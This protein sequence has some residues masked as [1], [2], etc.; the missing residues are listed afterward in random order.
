MNYEK[1][2]LECKNKYLKPKKELTG[3]INGQNQKGGNKKFVMFTKKEK[4]DIIKSYN[5]I[6][7]SD[8]KCV[9]HSRKDIINASKGMFTYPKYVMKK[10]NSGEI[11]YTINKVSNEK[12]N[13]VPIV[14]DDS[15]TVWCNNAAENYGL[16]IRDILKMKPGDR[17]EVI[18][19]DRN[20]GDYI[21]GYKKGKKYDPRKMG[22]TYGTYIHGSN[23]NGILIF[24]GDLKG[25]VYSPFTWEINLKAHNDKSYFWGPLPNNVDKCSMNKNNKR[26]NKRKK[27]KSL[28]EKIKVGWRGPSINLKDA[29]K[30]PNKVTHYSNWWNDYAPLRHHNYLKVNRKK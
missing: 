13:D 25:E 1:E 3:Q 16:E 18:F 5:K 29:N 27:E 17:M 10:K 23:L 21:H 12:G 19:M 6:L 15:M 24:G 28:N 14:Y 20:V 7:E 22:L 2:Y 26:N 30:L 11:C 8:K 4:N 9:E